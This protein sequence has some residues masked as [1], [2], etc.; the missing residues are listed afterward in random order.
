M[1]ETAAIRLRPFDASTVAEFHAAALESV[2]EVYP[3]LAWC[4]AGY[5]REE[6]ERWV[7]SRIQVF[8]DRH[9]YPFV[10][11]DPDGRFLGAIDLNQ[12]NRIHRMA[13]VGYWVRTSASGRG[14]A[15]AAVRQIADFAFDRTDLARLEILC[16]VGNVRSQ[17]VAEKVGANREGVLRDRIFMHGRSVDA[18]LY[19]IVRSAW[20]APSVLVPGRSE[21]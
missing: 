21:A 18:V 2:Q 8:A 5:S 15:T 6:A 13:N 12:I 17:R 4:H 10:V 3:W 19:S 1:S 14:V 7:A 20:P 9:E 11:A 16:A